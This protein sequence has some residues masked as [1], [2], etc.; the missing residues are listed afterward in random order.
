MSCNMTYDPANDGPFVSAWLPAIVPEAVHEA[1][2]NVKDAV[3][4]WKADGSPPLD[5]VSRVEFTTPSGWSEPIDSVIPKYAP[6]PAHEEVWAAV[7]RGIEWISKLDTPRTKLSGWSRAPW[8]EHED[9][10]DREWDVSEYVNSTI[11]ARTRLVIRRTLD[12]V[13]TTCGLEDLIRWSSYT[14]EDGGAVQMSQ[15]VAAPMSAL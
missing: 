5:W 14:G 3:R 13:G 4:V 2:Q 9:R 10:P 1:A 15:T 8:E 11:D 6:W 12:L 7:R